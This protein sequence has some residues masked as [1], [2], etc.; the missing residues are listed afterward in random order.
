MSP[1]GQRSRRHATQRGVRAVHMASCAVA[2]CKPLYVLCGLPCCRQP[3]RQCRIGSWPCAFAP[4]P[5]AA[6]LTGAL[7]P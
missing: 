3:M 6:V 7:K 1:P 5:V 2:A 4:H